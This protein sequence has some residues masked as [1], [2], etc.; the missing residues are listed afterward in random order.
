MPENNF[1]R[2]YPHI[3]FLQQPTPHP[4]PMASYTFIVLNDNFV[5]FILTAQVLREL[6]SL[7]V[8]YHAQAIPAPRHCQES[9]EARS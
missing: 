9:Y 4:K 6:L 7:S 3:N 1:M 5:C 2:Q 8:D